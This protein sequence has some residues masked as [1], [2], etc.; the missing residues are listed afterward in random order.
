MRTSHSPPP[1]SCLGLSLNAQPQK[2]RSMPATSDANDAR[3]LP[4]ISEVGLPPLPS[5]WVSTA[6]ALGVFREPVRF[7]YSSDGLHGMNLPDR[8]NLS[9]RLRTE[10]C[11]MFDTTKC[12]M[13]SEVAK[14]EVRGERIFGD[15]SPI[16]HYALRI[17]H[18]ALRITHYVAIE[19]RSGVKTE[20][21][22]GAATR[23]QR[24][25][26]KV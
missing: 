22:Q 7:W 19:S 23:P 10:C 1:Q 17:T 25:C 2:D 21:K 8:R 9:V 15:S 6:Q 14:C 4:V 20:S 12:E 11:V 3:G 18:Y 13:R 5:A 24:W 26:Q 16:T